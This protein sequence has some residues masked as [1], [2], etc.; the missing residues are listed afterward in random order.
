MTAILVTGGPGTLGSVLVPPFRAARHQ[1]RLPPAA[2]RGG[3]GH[4][5]DR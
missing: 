3:A 2:G 5:G 4:L 1:A